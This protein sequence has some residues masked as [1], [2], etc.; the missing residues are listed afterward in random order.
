MPLYTD[1]A[2]SHLAQQPL[3]ETSLGPD[4]AD[5]V[6]H[7]ALMIAQRLAAQHATVIP[8]HSARPYRERSEQ[9]RMAMRIGVLRVLEALVLLGW[10]DAPS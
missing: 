7:L 2:L 10:I 9:E 6:A 5:Q 8:P 4:G 1:S 3:P